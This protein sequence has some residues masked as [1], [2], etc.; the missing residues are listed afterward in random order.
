MPAMDCHDYD[1]I[2]QTPFPGHTSHLAIHVQGDRLQELS[3]VNVTNRPKA[4]ANPA[5]RKV[6]EQLNAYFE[7]PA[8]QFSIPLAPQGTDYQKRIWN[9][10][11]R[12]PMG[13]VWSYGDLAEMVRS[14]ARAVGNACRRNPLPIVVPCH[15]IV[16]ANGLGGYAGQTNGDNLAIKQWLLRHESAI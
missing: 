9:M 1:A 12:C 8:Y 4:P 15:R 14:G 13:K 6:V 3:F 7:D 11:R 5:A 10:M 16:S 2:M